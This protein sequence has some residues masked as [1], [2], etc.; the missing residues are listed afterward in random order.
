MNAKNLTNQQ[1]TIYKWILDEQQLP[2]F[3]NLY[4]GAIFLLEQ[5]PPGHVTFVAHAGREIVN[6]LASEINRSKHP[7]RVDYVDALNEI[8]KRWEN[9][10]GAP[11]LNSDSPSH[12]TIPR[13]VCEMLQS[14]INE[15]R[16]G[17]TTVTE[18]DLLALSTF[19]RYEDEELIPANFI[20]EW[21][22][23]RKWFQGHAHVP[24]D[25]IPSSAEI[26]LVAKHFQTLETY[27]SISAESQYK[28]IG[29]ID[30]LLQ[31]TNG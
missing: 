9:Q 24:R 6:R 4:K 21:K 19:L 27:L 7:P 5:K 12:Q 3:A 2:A 8:E 29:E 14:L 30:A 31:E 26:E 10:W 20:Q 11:A 16:K 17:H 25:K 13:E 23:A 15:H 18:R 22:E 1:K 28:R